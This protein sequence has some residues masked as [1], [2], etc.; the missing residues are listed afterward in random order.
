MERVRVPDL[1][2]AVMQGR[3]DI[4]EQGGNPRLALDQRP[5]A[6]VLAVEVQKIEQEEHQRGG[7]DAVGRHLDHL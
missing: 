1:V 5:H 4:G 3:T 6:E 7:I 2:I